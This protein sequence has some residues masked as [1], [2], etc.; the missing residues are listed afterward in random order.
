MTAPLV[1]VCLPNLNTRPFLEERVQTVLA[2]TLQ[3]WELVVSDNYSE[4]GAWELFQS[5]AQSEPRMHN[6]QA[7]RKGMYENW[8]NC[9]RRA[10]GKYV[11]IATSD[12]TMAPD[13]LEKM[14]R[15]L[16]AHPDC[17]LAHCTL[18]FIDEQG[19]D[20]PKTQ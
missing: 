4:D 2:Q 6:E 1:S 11:Y 7:A 9:I 14:A 16:E 3:D 10:T 8:N 17:D 5:I 20:L 13:C 19:L 15:A 18:R 12:D